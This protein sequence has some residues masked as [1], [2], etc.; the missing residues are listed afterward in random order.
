[1]KSPESQVKL[2]QF[3]IWYVISDQEDCFGLAQR[4]LR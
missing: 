2:Y 3:R 1:L 4:P